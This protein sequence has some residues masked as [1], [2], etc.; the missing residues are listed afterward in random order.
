MNA[1]RRALYNPLIRRLGYD[2]LEIDTA[3]TTLLRTRAIHQAA[4]AEDKDVLKELK[5]RFDHYMRTGDNSKIPADLQRIIFQSAV[6]YG[7]RKEYEFI[8]GICEKPPNPSASLSAIVAMG[9]SLDLKLIDETL[10]YIMTKS[11]DQDVIYFFSGLSRNPKDRRIL[12]EFFKKNYDALYIRFE[13]NFMLRYLIEY[14]FTG[15]SAEKDYQDIV[16][17]FKDKD[18]SKYSQ[19][20]AQVLESIRTKISWIDRSTD[21]MRKWLE[22]WERQ[23]QVLVGGDLP[24]LSI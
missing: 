6:Q 2:Y 13:G 3:D 4:L 8:K 9:S 22:K 18:T 17:F 1:F 16:E 24:F 12:V 23:K 11:R 10:E 20:L 7:G 19:A 15:L 21:D 14:S 5:T